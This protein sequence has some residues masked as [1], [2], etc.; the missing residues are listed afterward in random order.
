MERVV[1]TVKR[2]GEARVRDLEVP[3]EVEAGRLAELVAEALRWEVDAAGQRLHYEIE[4]HPLGRTLQPGESLAAAGVWDG[5]WLVFRVPGGGVPA[6][7]RS[8]QRSTPR[9]AGV[10]GSP[11]GGWRPLVLPGDAD[12][13]A[14]PAAN[15]ADEVRRE[16]GFVWKQID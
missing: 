14:P 1:V 3:A 5:A 16:S 6:G 12:E 7:G 8:A 9:G 10:P 13:P 11:V 4:A 2:Q 15:P